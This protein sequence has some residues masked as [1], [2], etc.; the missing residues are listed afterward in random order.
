MKKIIDI[1]RLGKDASQKVSGFLRVVSVSKKLTFIWA[2]AFI[3]IVGSASL[4]ISGFEAHVINVTA[5][6][7]QNLCDARSKGYWANNEGCSHGA[8]SSIWAAEIN[9]LSSRFS[10]VFSGHTGGTI[11]ADLW[12]PNCPSGHTIEGKLCRAKA[13]AL[14]DELNV[15]SNHLDLNALIA[16]AFDG[17]KA[18]NHLHLTALSTVEEAL[19]A[20]ESIIENNFSTKKNLRD[21]A[22]VAERIYKFYGKQNPF[23][24]NCVYDPDDIPRCLAIHGD[25]FIKNKSNADVTNSVG[26]VSNTGGNSASGG[27]GDVDTGNASST[28]ETINVVNTDITDICGCEGDTGSSTAS[29]LNGDGDS[30]TST[31]SAESLALTENATSTPPDITEEEE[32]IATSTPPVLDE[33]SDPEPFD[34]SEEMASSTPEVLDNADNSE[35]EMDDE[36][37]IAD[38]EVVEDDATEENIDEDP[39]IEVVEPEDDNPPPETDI[40]VDITDDDSEPD[41]LPVEPSDVPPPEDDSGGGDEGDADDE[42]STQEASD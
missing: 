38:D 26:V 31:S 8:G 5:Q 22:Y 36:K 37:E 2:L 30:A 25:I 28:A 27:G 32:D 29:T 19:I 12:L 17:N 20:I 39:P 3:T 18:F 9:D 33:E 35:E 14:A 23:A 34:L 24:P 4:L 42:D 11:C 16:G 6:I 7:E 1:R 10:G 40:V 41:A 15:V 21:A 13:H